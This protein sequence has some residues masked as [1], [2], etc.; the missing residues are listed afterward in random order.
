MSFVPLAAGKEAELRWVRSAPAK[1]EFDLLAGDDR[2][3]QLRWS[4]TAGSLAT[5][6]A[7]GTSWTVKRGGFLNPH[8]TLRAAGGSTDLA[9]VTIHWN[10]HRIEVPGQGAFPFRRAGLLVP[11]WEVLGPGSARL[12]HIE[13]VRE[14]R[15]LVG[16][17]VEIAPNQLPATTVLL[18]VVL[19]WYFI[20]LAWFEDEALADWSDYVEGRT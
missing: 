7:S 18:L 5:V 16:G 20:V 15:K 11:A 14:A 3:A 1:N 10:Q 13:P 2:L 9:R 8:V 12:A 17:T 4:K 6:E 19:A